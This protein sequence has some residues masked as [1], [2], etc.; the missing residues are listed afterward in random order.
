MAGSAALDPATLEG[1]LIQGD[2]DRGATGNT[3]GGT[4]ATARNII[5]GNLDGVVVFQANSNNIQGNFI[6]RIRPGRLPLPIRETAW[7]WTWQPV[8]TSPARPAHPGD[9]RQPRPRDHD[10]GRQLDSRYSR[11]DLHDAQRRFYP[12]LG[13]VTNAS[14]SGNLTILDP[15]GTNPVGTFSFTSATDTSFTG[16]STGTIVTGD[17]VVAGAGTAAL[18]QQRG[19]GQF[20]RHQQHRQLDR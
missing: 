16:T 4:T 20:H 5:S 6:G 12:T 2:S 11:L 1:V 15:T 8:T 3:I 10:H 9:L 18:E 7:S 17:I 14:P 19:P 13:A